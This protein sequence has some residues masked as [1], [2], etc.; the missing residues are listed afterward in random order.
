[1]SIPSRM[2]AR[3]RGYY[4]ARYAGGALPGGTA[5]GRYLA[6]SSKRVWFGA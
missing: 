4:E 3:P 6:V 2:T 5:V 1:M